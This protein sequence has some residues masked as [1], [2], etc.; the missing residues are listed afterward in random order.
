[1]FPYDA[2]LLASLSKT[3]D[4][5]AEVLAI[6]Q[7]IDAITVD[8]DGLKWFNGLY[9][10]VTQAVHDRIAAGGF[11]DPAYLSELDVQFAQLYFAALR[12]SLSGS[13]LPGCWQT[14]FSRRDQAELT[15]LQFALAGVNAHI[16]HDLPMALVSTG[17][18]MNLPPGHDTVQYSDY[19]ALNS[20]LDSLIEEA[21]HTLNVR[22]LGEVLPPA[23]QLEDTV[24]AW[25]ISAAREAAWNNAEILWRLRPEDLLTTSFLD[26]LDGLTTVVSK[27]LLVAVPG[28]PG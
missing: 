20:T 2:E 17:Q 9:F 18:N 15:R 21:K 3:P 4:S 14:L 1:M 6:M 23:A 27:S 7:A 22:L 26:T 5:V 13:A 10:R 11:T 25:S 16:N 8:G 24:A 19:T 28:V 12:E